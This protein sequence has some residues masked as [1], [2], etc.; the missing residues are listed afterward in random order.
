[1]Y[2]EQYFLSF[3]SVSFFLRPPKCVRS[4]T[5]RTVSVFFAM[6]STSR[7]IV[8]SLCLIVLHSPLSARTLC[9]P[10]CLYTGLVCIVNSDVYFLLPSCYCC[11][12][13]PTNRIVARIAPP[14]TSNPVNSR[15]GRR[16]SR[17]KGPPLASLE[18]GDLPPQSKVRTF[19]HT[20]VQK[21][22][23]TRYSSI[24]YW[25]RATAVLV[26]TAKTTTSDCKL[27]LLKNLKLLYDN[28]I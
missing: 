15:T 9:P 3:T 4:A 25:G 17:F 12:V 18:N 23:Y 2:P 20:R 19:V 8:S 11:D 22:R 5:A 10:S 6:R 13:T 7:S 26:Q 24:P 14:S 21:I 27:V 16:L 28:S 1:M